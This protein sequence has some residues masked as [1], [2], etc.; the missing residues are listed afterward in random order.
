MKRVLFLYDASVEPG[1]LM[2]TIADV[3][4][5][6]QLTGDTIEPVLKKVSLKPPFIN[7][8]IP[9]E[10]MR[11]N[12]GPLTSGEYAAALCLGLKSWEKNFTKVGNINYGKYNNQTYLIQALTEP[13]RKYWT[14]S[15]PN[16]K[17]V[18]QAP[19]TLLHELLHARE[20]D[21]TRFGTVHAHLDDLDAAAR[22]L[23]APAS[24]IKSLLETL[25]GL[26]R[27]L[28]TKKGI[29]E[30]P[31][32]YAE[33][34]AT[35]GNPLAPNFERD[36]IVSFSLPYPLRYAGQTVTTSRCHKLM[37]PV[38]KAVLGELKAKG[39][40]KHVQNYSGIYAAR[41]QRD[42]NRLSLH[43]FG[44]AIDVEAEQYPRGSKKRMPQEVVD[45]FMAHGFV[46][47]RDFP[48]PDEQHFQYAKGY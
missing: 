12:V 26:V 46:H 40:D 33:I 48:T 11:E 34:V 9:V 8:T 14:S 7:S 30:V 28:A 37:I 3:Q 22:L 38:F 45:V 19:E 44:A 5:R 42:S 16:K 27:K 15:S 39:L 24:P 1:W 47:G 43:A 2:K 20:A 35:F 13:G 25:L 6:Y 36:N 18:L 4:E 29:P 41:T 21:L 10:W 23:K 17:K 32:G 31:S